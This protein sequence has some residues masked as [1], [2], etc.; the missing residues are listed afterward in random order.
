MTNEAPR[1][2]KPVP[3]H[4]PLS[5]YYGADERRDAY[6]IDLFDRTAHHYDTIE[7]LFLNGGLLYR[8]LSLRV[9]GLRPGMKVLDVAVGTAAV[10]R[11]AAKIVGPEG[12]VFGVDPS[13]GM[14]RQAEKNFSGPL[15]RGYAQMLP[16]A[17]DAFDYVTMGIAL[18]HVPDLISTFGEYLRVLKPGGTLWILESHVPKSKL[19][20]ALTKFAW[21]KLIPWM[22]LVSTR[23]REAKLLMD[24]YWDTVEN[25][26]EPEAIRG[27]LDDVGFRQTRATLI[28][29]GA[30]IEYG[31]RK[32]EPAA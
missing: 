6:V 17:D 18:R 14:L 27:A 8:Q 2:T 24:Y 30:F 25:C 32:A 13:L 31:G 7:A 26:V 5:Q 20:H 16:F 10:A 1:A 19:G 23:S 12:R 21:A 9:S 29:P 11:G 15:A 22:T 28:I 3:P 4:P